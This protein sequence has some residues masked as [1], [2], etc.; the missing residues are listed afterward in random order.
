M[1]EVQTTG[2]VDQEGRA[3]H[4]SGAPLVGLSDEQIAQRRKRIGSSDAAAICGEDQYRTAADVYLEKVGDLEPSRAEL[5]SPADLGNRFQDE[6]I[7][8]L[9]ASTGYAVSRGIYVDGDPLAANLDGYVGVLDRPHSLP[10]FHVEHGTYAAQ[11]GKGRDEAIVV[12]AKTTGLEGWGDVD[13]GAEAVPP[14]VLVQTHFQM[15]LTGARVALVPVLFGRFGLK[16]ALYRVER[17]VGLVSAVIGKCHAFWNDHV[18]PRVPP[19][20]SVPRV[21]TLMRMRRV[22]GKTVE[23]DRGLIDAYVGIGEAIKK[24]TKLRDDAKAKL[25]AAM[26]DAVV[27]DGGGVRAN[28]TQ[29]KESHVEYTRRAHWRIKVKES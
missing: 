17:D 18:C 27:G 19:P 14:Q 9:E 21:E 24:A 1:N 25:L 4:L 16:F 20:D 26:G 8:L 6:L 29:I 15:A 2:Q 23:V 13:G 22:E 28:L 10:G 12:E 5:A 11:D 7:R 3:R